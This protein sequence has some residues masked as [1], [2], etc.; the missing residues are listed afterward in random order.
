MTDDDGL[1]I[2]GLRVPD[3]LLR[4]IH[5]DR[6]VAP[7]DPALLAAIFGETP[8]QPIFY[9]L[10]GILRENDSWHSDMEDETRE[11]YV[12]SESVENPPGDIEPAR[13]L[14]IGDLGPD[15]PFALDYRTSDSDPSVVY[16][17]SD[18]GWVEI[19]PNIRAF[20]DM[21]GLA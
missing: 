3:P 20:L 17:R 8:P 11:C 5:E 10:N 2:G 19:A 15:Q 12:G 6:W 16:L 14:L 1:I 4:V 18:N 21:L 9:K 13:S 7:K